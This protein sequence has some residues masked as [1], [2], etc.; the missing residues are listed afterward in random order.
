MTTGRIIRVILGSSKSARKA[1]EPKGVVL[2]TESGLLKTLEGEAPNLPVGYCNCDF[3]VM[4]NGSKSARKAPEAKRVVLIT[5]SGLLKS[6]EGE[7]P[8]CPLGICNCDF[9]II[10]GTLSEAREMKVI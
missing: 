10:M 4:L 9:Q 8:I 5:E 6:L 2:S 3:L 1:S 7:T